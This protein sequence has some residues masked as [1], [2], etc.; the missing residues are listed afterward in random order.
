VDLRAQLAVIKT[1]RTMIV[2]A[3]ALAVVAALVVSFIQPKMYASQA[4]MVV[5]QSLTAVNPD[6]N[7][8]TVSQK[9]GQTYAT[10][11]TTRPILDAVIK[12]LGLSMTSDQL[13]SQVS[14][15][16][17]QDSSLLTISANA[18]DPDQAAAIA[19]DI[20]KQLINVSPTLQ[21]TQTDIQQFVNAQLTTIQNQIKTAQ[22]SL[23]A[24]LGQASPSPAQTAQ[25]ANLQAQLQ[26]LRT[27][28]A[29]LLAFASNSAANELSVVDPA[30][31]NSSPSSPKIILNVLIALL[32]GGLLGVGGAFLIDYLDD[33]VKSADDLERATGLSMLGS[34]PKMRLDASKSQIYSLATLVYPR[35]SVAESFRALRTNL[36]FTGIDAPVTTILVTSAMP[37]EGKT[38][39]ATNLAVAFAQAG[40][41]TVLV[42]ADLRR[43]EVHKFFSLDNRRGLTSIL[44]SDDVGIADVALGT[45]DANL[46]IVTSGPPPPNPA[47]LIAS[48]RMTVILERLKLSAEVVIIDSPPVNLVT[49]A[50]ILV[51]HVD[52]AVLVVDAGRTSRSAARRATD[53]LVL[54]G[55]RVLGAAM[56]RGPAANAGDVYGYYEEDQKGADDGQ[57]TSRTAA[58]AAREPGR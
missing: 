47:E 25:I 53:A 1:R 27:T 33:S 30:V 34:I 21:G 38:T 51:R 22:A 28:Y 20:A 18:S 12:D 9:L 50:A 31:S 57:S 45:E 42:D 55:G 39:V 29:G 6:I 4:T 10:I 37:R 46:R 41:R 14:A 32:L 49:D 54:V 35:S 48:T 11:A 36:E 17:A 8:L 19:N 40:H 44:R 26:S 3:V 7:Q 15:S 24:L 23:D 16:I 43:P 13:R 52:G 2:A 58:A 56:N 5:G